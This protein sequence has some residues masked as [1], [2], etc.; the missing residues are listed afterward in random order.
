MKRFLAEMAGTF[1]LIAIGTGSIVVNAQSYPLGEF[2]IALSFGLAVTA[3][4]Y[5]FGNISGAHIN[6][7]VTLGFALNGNL[8]TKSAIPYFFAQFLGALAGSLLVLALYPNVADLGSTHPSIPSGF[9]FG[10]EVFL[11]FVLMFVILW[12]SSRGKLLMTALMVGATVGLEAYFFGP[13][14][15]ASMNPARSLGPAITEGRIDHLWIYILA[16][17]MGA[18]LAVPAWLKIQKLK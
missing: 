13:F 4:I 15:G 16:P 2:G 8:T 17:L 5:L 14:T 18:S 3:A 12:I 9:A 7:A 6:P 10:I 1:L 11:T